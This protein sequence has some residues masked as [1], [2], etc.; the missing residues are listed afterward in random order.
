MNLPLVLESTTYI[1]YCHY[2]ER[3]ISKKKNTNFG[4]MF[5]DMD[6]C[7]DLLVFFP[8]GRNGVQRKSAEPHLR[9]IQ[10]PDQTNHGEY[11][12]SSIT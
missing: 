3:R 7:Q 4:V 10:D 1:E 11:D 9:A 2:C 6:S 5:R 12:T 8:L